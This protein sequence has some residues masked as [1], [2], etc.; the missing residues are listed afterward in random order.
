MDGLVVLGVEVTENIIKI[1]SRAKV[2]VVGRV[3]G[4]DLGIGSSFK[5]KFTPDETNTVFVDPLA[6]EPARAIGKYYEEI[7]KQDLLRFESLFRDEYFDTAGK[8]L[9]DSHKFDRIYLEYL[10]GDAYL[11][12]QTRGDKYR[13]NKHFLNLI[14]KY[15]KPGGTIEILG[16]QPYFSSTGTVETVKI[17]SESA[18]NKNQITFKSEHDEPASHGPKQSG[19]IGIYR[20]KLVDY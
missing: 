11:T 12:T 17:F 4:S 20:K 7:E 10:V 15:L 2:L 19:N 13:A 1:D 16:F 6:K 9:K 8:L 3:P 18:D 5:M 14:D